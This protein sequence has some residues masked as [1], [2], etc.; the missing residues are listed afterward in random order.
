MHRGLQCRVRWIRERKGVGVTAVIDEGFIVV[1][2]VVLELLLHFSTN[3][4]WTH[5]IL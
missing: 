2:D 3:V 1:L 4:G 5:N